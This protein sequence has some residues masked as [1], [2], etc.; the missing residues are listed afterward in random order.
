MADDAPPPTAPRIMGM[1]ISVVFK[2]Q[3]L[4]IQ[5]TE[6]NGINTGHHGRE[7]QIK[8]F[9]EASQEVGEEFIIVERVVR[10]REL[11]IKVT[12]LGVVIA[13][14]QLILLGRG[15]GDARVHHARSCL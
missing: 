7:H 12:H 8:I 10:G 2:A 11:I 3:K 5:P 4:G 14:R 1:Q 15:E 6:S 13:D 9:V